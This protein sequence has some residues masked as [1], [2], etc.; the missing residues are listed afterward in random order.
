MLDSR[1]LI[2]CLEGFEYGV[3]SG[4]QVSINPH[5]IE[6]Q[7]CA[8]GMDADFQIRD[9]TTAVLR[10]TVRRQQQQQGGSH[11]AVAPIFPATATVAELAFDM[12]QHFQQPHVS[13]AGQAGVVIIRYAPRM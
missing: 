13:M 9:S 3:P 12:P 10:L 11:F 1:P 7:V 8:F 2:T 5:E 6:V 4:Y